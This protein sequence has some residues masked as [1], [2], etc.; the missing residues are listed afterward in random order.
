MQQYSP[1]SQ[2]PGTTGDPAENQPEKRETSPE[3]AGGDP[4]PH[5]QRHRRRIKIRKRIRIRKKPSA[6]KKIRKIAEIAAWVAIIAGFII[7]LVIMVKELDIRDEKFK[8]LQ[9]KTKQ[10]QGKR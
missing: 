2:D 8:Q 7:T 10:S 5:G 1:E 4:H 3:E 6:K 9:K